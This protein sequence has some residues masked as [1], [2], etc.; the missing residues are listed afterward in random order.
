MSSLLRALFS[1]FGKRA[2]FDQILNSLFMQAQWKQKCEN[3]NSDACIFV[4]GSTVNE[5][6]NALWSELL[7]LY[8]GTVFTYI[9]ILDGEH[10]LSFRPQHMQTQ[11]AF[12]QQLEAVPHPRRPYFVWE[13]VLQ[14]SH[15][16]PVWLTRFADA[17]GVSTCPRCDISHALLLLPSAHSVF[18]FVI[19]MQ[20]ISITRFQPLGQRAIRPGSSIHL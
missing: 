7:R 19:F 10:R 1:V 6:R 4:P 5:G 13:Q 18:A 9:I 14:C 16:F 12:L 15:C 11:H 8:P 17:F 3:C 2:L 20:Q